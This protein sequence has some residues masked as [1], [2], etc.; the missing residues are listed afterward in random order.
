MNYSGFWCHWSLSAPLMCIPRTRH[1]CELV[2]VSKFSAFQSSQRGQGT[3]A[4]LVV[5]TGQCWSTHHFACLIGCLVTTARQW[6]LDLGGLVGLFG[7]IC[8]I[9]NHQSYILGGLHGRVPV[10]LW[11]SLVAEDGWKKH[12]FP[13][14]F[15]SCSED[16]W[17]KKQH[18]TTKITNLRALSTIL[19]LSSRPET[20]KL[21]W[22]LAIESIL[23]TSRRLYSRSNWFS[24]YFKPSDKPLRL[25]VVELLQDHVH[26][27][28]E[29]LNF[30]AIQIIHWYSHDDYSS[31]SWLFS[32]SI[33]ATNLDV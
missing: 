7:V 6:T 17:P 3:Q 1:L 14:Y 29:I 12:T 31:H 32:K 16:Q 27:S 33:P 24:T 22:M 26:F 10:V 30:I 15:A 9:V 11:I 13:R 23:S 5:S 28:G 18:K 21:T 8:I 4:S 2:G 19:H 20:Q 25:T